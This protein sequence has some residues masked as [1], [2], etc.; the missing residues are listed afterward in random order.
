VTKSGNIKF[1]P[2]GGIET[3]SW[4]LHL[5]DA[6]GNRHSADIP[7]DVDAANKQWYFIKLKRTYLLIMR[8]D[9]G[10]TDQERQ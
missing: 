6:H 5:E 1:E 7:F 8:S 9:A 3:T 2:P 10:E 4:V